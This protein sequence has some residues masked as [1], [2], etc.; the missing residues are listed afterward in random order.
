VARET[1]LVTLGFEPRARWVSGLPFRLALDASAVVAARKGLGRFQAR[2]LRE[3]SRLGAPEVE[4]VVLVSDGFGEAGVEVP[5]GWSAEVLRARRAVTRELVLG[6][7]ALRRLG[8]DVYL[9]STD[10]LRVPRGVPAVLMAFEHPAYRTRMNALGGLGGERQR[11][12]DALTLWWWRRT[13]H[14]ADHI[15][16]ASTSTA[17]DLVFHAGVDPRKISVSRPGPFQ[18]VDP[19]RGSTQDGT[20]ILTFIDRDPRDNGE[21]VLDAFSR[22][23]GSCSLSVVGDTD[24]RIV[25]RAQRLGI[26]GRVTF[27]GRLQDAELRLTYASSDVYLDA[28]LYEGYGAQAAEAVACGLP[29]V[30]S[31]VT[32]L[33]EVTRYAASYVNPHDAEQIA[34]TLRDLL[35]RPPAERSRPAPISPPAQEWDRFL[36]HLLAHCQH[37]AGRSRTAAAGS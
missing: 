28:S 34:A 16:A 32:A 1:S 25:R 29:C 21:V 37:L 33:P 20:R 19:W 31:G 14:R 5:R 17:R 22:L 9:T 30:V 36:R 13:V 11:A 26:G 8:A 15:V 12:S 10:R 2:L 7:R 6:P 24:D 18:D 35:A 3:L 27:H 23:P 4:G